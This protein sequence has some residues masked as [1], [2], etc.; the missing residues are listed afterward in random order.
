MGKGINRLS[1]GLN[2]CGILS[3]F[4]YIALLKMTY[5]YAPRNEMNC[6]DNNI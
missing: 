1:F 6:L 3:K 2:L 5:D 4:K